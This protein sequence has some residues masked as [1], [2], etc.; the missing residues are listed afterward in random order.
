V[1]KKLVIASAALLLGLV[2]SPLAQAHTVL[3]S[4]DPGAG[5]TVKQLPEQVTLTFAGSLLTLGSK[6]I[7][8]VEVVDPMGQTITSANNVV[9]GNVLTNVLSPSMVMSGSYKVIFRVAAQDGH[10]LNG[11]FNFAVGS[12]ASNGVHIAIPK[13]GTVTLYAHATGQGVM[14]SKGAP[15]GDASGTFLI[16][17]SKQTICFSVKT[18]LNDVSAI[19][20]HAASQMNMTMS[21]EIFLPLDIAALTSTQPICHKETGSALATVAKF[22]SHYV[23]MLHTKK[24]PDGAV[25]GFLHK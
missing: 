2:V 8:T 3:V 6:A 23:L 18:N 11:S 4:S 9:H 19:H 24:Y 16:D 17:F 7:N 13:S 10:V 12:G 5:S 20:L 1:I 15:S 25:A 21:D 14:D 22:P